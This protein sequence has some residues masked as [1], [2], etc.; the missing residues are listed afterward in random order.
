MSP[1]H[2]RERR[3]RTQASLEQKVSLGHVSMEEKDQASP[4]H[5]GS[6]RLTAP[7]TWAGETP[8]VNCEVMIT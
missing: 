5:Q 7:N 6:F 8:C 4:E 1:W 3:R 2:R